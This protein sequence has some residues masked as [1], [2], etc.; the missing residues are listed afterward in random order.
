[1]FDHLGIVVFDLDLARP[2]YDACLAPLAIQLLQHNSDDS[3]R[4]LVYGTEGAGPFFVVAEGAP[5]FW[6]DAHRASA[7]PIHV[8]FVAPDRSAVDAFHR[9]GLA[10][11]GL[12]NGPPGERR[13]A[14]PYYAAFVIDPDGNNIEAGH[15]GPASESVNAAVDDEG[16]R[17]RQRLR[18]A[19]AQNP[20][21]RRRSV[22]A[23]R[24]PSSAEAASE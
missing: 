11:G 15:R 17:E 21:L 1:M 9:A 13:S 22:P 2:F 18:E 6:S 12:D 16:G 19:L 10:H 8:A 14:T 7:A 4:W 24:D 20:R 23:Q 5:G 3:G